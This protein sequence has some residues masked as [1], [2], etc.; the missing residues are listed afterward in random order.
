MRFR[1]NTFKTCTLDS[2]DAY[3]L[4]ICESFCFRSS[5]LASLSNLL[6]CARLAHELHLL[7]ILVKRTISKV[8]ANVQ[9][10]FCFSKWYF[11]PMVSTSSFQIVPHNMFI[12]NINEWTKNDKRTL[13][14]IDYFS[15]N[16]SWKNWFIFLDQYFL[17]VQRPIRSIAAYQIELSNLKKDF[18]VLTVSVALLFV[19]RFV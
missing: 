15:D 5:L 19:H 12:P 3:Q 13:F 9:S 7:K 18:F 14:Y 1:R 11:I 17:A 8:H 2:V 16:I 10:F 4:C 6:A